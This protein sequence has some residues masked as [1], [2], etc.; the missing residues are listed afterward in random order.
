MAKEVWRGAAAA[1]GDWQ[2]TGGADKGGAELDAQHKPS[3]LKER[4]LYV[5]K[6]KLAFSGQATAVETFQKRLER[7]R[8]FGRDR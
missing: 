8:Q 7:E 3:T 2:M 1:A 4:L 5:R 6:R